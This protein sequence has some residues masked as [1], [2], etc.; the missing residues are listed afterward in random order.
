MENL[1]DDHPSGVKLGEPARFLGS[2]MAREQIQ[3]GKRSAPEDASNT[4]IASQEPLVI[5]SSMCP[6]SSMP[7]RSSRP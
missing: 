3:A 6:C 5:A 4:P 7:N 2:S 1:A